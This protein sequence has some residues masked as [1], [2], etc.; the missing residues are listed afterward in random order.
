MNAQDLADVGARWQ[1]AM[2]AGDW[3]AAWQQTDRIELPRRAAQGRPGFVRDASQLVWDGT[4]VAGRSVRV[5]CLRGLGDALQFMRFVPALQ[6]QARELHFLVPPALLG[7][8]QGAPGLGLVSNAWTDHPPPH[9]VEFEVMELAYACRSTPATVPPP[10]PLADWVRQ[11]EVFMLPARPEEWRVGLVWGASAWD[12]SRSIP[13]DRLDPL[14]RTPGVRFYDLQQE[15]TERDARMVPLWRRTA[16][17]LS[18]AAA[19]LELDLVITIDGMPAHLAATLGRPTWLLLKHEADWR[20]GQSR[21]DTPWYPT[22]RLFRQPAPDDWDGV[23]SEVTRALA[24]EVK[25]S[26]WR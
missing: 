13:L 4:P 11:R 6:A 16:D 23:I 2:L 19:L 5:R 26:R 9:E 14:L 25:A 18:A 1:A 21:S 17:A 24:D 22:M 15:A 7:L 8:L 20:W 3:E 12:G 10:Y